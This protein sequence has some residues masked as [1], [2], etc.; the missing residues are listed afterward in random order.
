MG[1]FL[2]HV[3]QRSSHGLTEPAKHN[4]CNVEDGRAKALYGY[5]VNMTV[6]RRAV[7]V[8]CL[9]ARSA[10]Y[11]RYGYLHTPTYG[12][13]SGSF[14]EATGIAPSAD[15]LMMACKLRGNVP[16]ASERSK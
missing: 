9:A 6:H 10:A 11:K 14:E 8:K 3:G 5:T 15:L 4:E 1:V 7:N 13:M 2:Q 12:K 16:C